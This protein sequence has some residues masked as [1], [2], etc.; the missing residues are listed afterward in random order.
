MLVLTRKLGE[1]VIVGNN[2]LITVLSTGGSRVKL[3]VQA[4]VEVAIIRSEINML[5]CDESSRSRETS[6]VTK[7]PREA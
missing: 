1:S 2:I 3:G 4:P 5:D 7:E 6:T